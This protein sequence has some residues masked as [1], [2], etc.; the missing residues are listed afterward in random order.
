MTKHDHYTEKMKYKNS[1]PEEKRK[2]KRRYKAGK[3]AIKNVSI[4]D[5]QYIEEMF[6]DEDE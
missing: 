5:L 1:K 6:E 2:P 3:K 4:D